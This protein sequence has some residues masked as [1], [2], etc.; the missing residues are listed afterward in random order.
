MEKMRRLASGRLA[1]VVGEKALSVDKFAVT[2]GFRRIAEK[3]YANMS[4]EEKDILQSYA[5]GVNDFVSNIK[6]TGEGST[7]R[8]LPPEFYVLGIFEMEPWSPVDSLS[9]L[10]LMNFHL[11]W[12]WN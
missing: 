7:A 4:Q 11:T 6:L 1:E 10:K 2:I 9:L 3:T 12:N 5:D 8:L